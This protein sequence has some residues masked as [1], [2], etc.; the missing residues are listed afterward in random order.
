M[1]HWYRLDTRVFTRVFLPVYHTS[2]QGGSV[3][4]CTATDRSYAKL[5]IVT[6]E[7]GLTAVNKTPQV[8]YGVVIFPC[9]DFFA[10]PA[11]R[12]ISFHF[13]RKSQ[14][15]ASIPISERLL[16]EKWRSKAVF[17]IWRQDVWTFWAEAQHRRGGWGPCDW[18]QES[19]GLWT[20]QCA[21]RM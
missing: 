12:E 2:T 18:D 14:T 15:F 3:Q 11:Y 7:S 16:L 4:E 10:F 21:V 19:I 8:G 20:F 5:V 6:M 13:R 9:K 1:S 17:T